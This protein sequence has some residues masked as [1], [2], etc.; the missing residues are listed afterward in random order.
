MVC[1]AFGA[2]AAMGL[3]G[4]RA[5]FRDVVIEHNRVPV[6]EVCRRE[7]DGEAD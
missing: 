5:Y 7:T 4:E 2:L 1:N 6:G 3:N